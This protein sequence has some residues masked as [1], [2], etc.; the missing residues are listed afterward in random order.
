MAQ[1]FSADAQQ[2]ASAVTITGTT[3]TTVIS[4]NP[5]QPPFETAK[6]V[7]SAIVPI[8]P[9]SDATSLTLKLYRNASGEDQLLN[10]VDVQF[11]ASAN[12]QLLKIMATD[13]IPD[14]RACSYTVTV[15]QAGGTA[16]GSAKV[17]AVISAML[18]SG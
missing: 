4:T 18:I 14:G 16:N 7:V 17:G 13:S 3:E 5:L 2:L 8:T 10:T 6:G 9:G 12:D 15:T 1:I 11:G